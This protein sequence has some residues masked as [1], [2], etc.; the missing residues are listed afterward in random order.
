M[1]PVCVLVLVVF[2]SNVTFKNKEKKNVWLGLS[3]VLSLE[4]SACVSKKKTKF[5]GEGRLN[6]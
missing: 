6:H 1:Q 3:S 4:R 2:P 5:Y